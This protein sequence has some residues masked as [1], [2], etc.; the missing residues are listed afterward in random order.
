[1]VRA[2]RASVLA[3]AL[4][5]A[6]TAASAQVCHPV[7]HHHHHAVHMRTAAIHR[8]TG[9]GVTIDQARLISFPQPVKTVF[10]GNP[11][12]VDIS[13][14]DS[15]HA[16]LLGKTF[17]ETNMIA[18]GPDG[19]QISNQQVTVLNN[20]AAVTVNR[21]PDQFDY[22]C[23]RGHCETAPRPGDPQQFVSPTETAT[24][25]HEAAAAASATNTPNQAQASSQ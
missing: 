11:T 13:M 12:I 14:I 5:L 8:P 23:T 20:G 18:L 17:G 7:H 22:M 25:Q 3:L 2:Y 10:V 16:F 19:K 1:M 15:Q 6:A 9:V 24:T 4:P 21:G